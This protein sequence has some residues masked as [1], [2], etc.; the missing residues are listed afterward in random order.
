MVTFNL[1]S[2]DKKTSRLLTLDKP[3]IWTRLKSL[4]DLAQSLEI[5]TSAIDA[6]NLKSVPDPWGHITS[7]RD[8]LFAQENAHPAHASALRIWRAILALLGTRASQSRYTLRTTLVD[9]AAAEKNGRDGLFPA[10]ARRFAPGESFDDRLNWDSLWLLRSSLAGQDE[11]LGMLS[12]LTLVVPARGMREGLL[13][14][15]AGALTEFGSPLGRSLYTP[16]QLRALRE[17]LANIATS[18]RIATPGSTRL[19]ELLGDYQR[20]LD[21]AG[22]TDA[23]PMPVADTR[24]L[25][26]LPAGTPFA[27]LN[28]VWKPGEVQEAASDATIEVSEDFKRVF[29]GVVLADA[30]LSDTLQRPADRIVLWRG[31]RL[32]AL[33]DLEKIRKDAHLFETHGYLVVTPDD[34]FSAVLAPLEGASIAAHGPSELAHMLLPVTPLTLLMWPIKGLLDNLSL[35]EEGPGRWVAELKLKLIDKAGNKYNH[36][37]RREFE[38]PGT[39]R[40]KKSHLA[41]VGPNNEKLDAPFA[42]AAWPDFSSP[43]WKWNFLHFSADYNTAAVP[44]SGFSTRILVKDLT[45]Q[46]DC[47]ARWAKLAK[48]ASAGGPWDGYASRMMEGSRSW[49]E[50]IRYAT[51]DPMQREGSEREIERCD[52]GFDAVSFAAMKPS[53][54]ASGA[55]DKPAFA[56]IGLMS[57]SVVGKQVGDMAAEVATDF[58]TTNTTIYAKYGGKQ[59]EL[60]FAQ[61]LRTFNSARGNPVS[62]Y[63]AY[64][65][66]IPYSDIVPPFT[67][68]MQGRLFDLRDAD[69]DSLIVN[70]GDPALWRD[71]IFFDKNIAVTMSSIWDNSNGPLHFNIKWSEDTKDRERIAR[72]LRQAG[73][74]TLAE[75]TADGVSPEDVRW[76]Y[77][78]PMAMSGP[79][80]AN[81]RDI[82]T[83]VVGQLRDPGE[84][85]QSRI[86]PQTVGFCT[87]S[88]AAAVWYLNRSRFKT[89]SQIVMDIGGGTTDMALWTERSPVWAIPSGWRAE[90]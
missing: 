72:F 78:Y 28:R 82:A 86:P 89:T 76:R 79:D 59:R 20:D 39:E 27:A 81:F 65:T 26:E 43:Q 23:Y 62:D 48:W 49:F 33:S 36:V 68:V 24:P 35:R 87:E 83:K 31:F 56:G 61:R 74:M 37:L 67:T 41:I 4:D 34:L 53:G 19:M 25:G 70:A 58:G 18:V 40:S 88:A 75:L 60:H 32:S 73:F 84:P 90:T 38:A 30:A 3:A 85:G 54:Y 66:F 46:P 47:A 45:D 71:Y 22:A 5:S 64:A 69:K 14:E 10:I 80:I 44:T 9:L 15:L 11:L 6:S 77:S 29:A 52:Y 42:L 2:L 1:P 21:Q 55:G 16:E 57:P 51:Y 12:P 50:R 8:A 17:F 13:S 63:S 7:F